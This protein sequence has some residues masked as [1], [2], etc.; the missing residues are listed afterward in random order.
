[1][2]S[3]CAMTW[4]VEKIINMVLMWDLWNISFFGRGDVSPTHSEL[5]RF[6]LGSKAKHQVSFPVVILL[7]INLSPSAI[8]IMSL[9]DVTRSSL[10]SG[11]KECGTN[12]AHNF[13][14]PKSC[15]S[16]WCDLKVIFTKSATAAMF[17]SVRLD[18]GHP[19]LSSSSTSSLPSQNWE[20][21]L[22]TLNRFRFS[23]PSAFCTNTSVCVADRQA[24]QQNFMATLFSFLPSMTY[25][26]NWLYMTS[27]NSY[28][29]EGKQTKLGV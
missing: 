4:R 19:P 11:V 18:F 20:Y 25:K 5:C 8:A 23:L 29:V 7:K 9:K 21:Q 1:M 24:L 22:K 26:D 15:F 12:R 16:V 17:T 6:V 14:F 3:L 13:I 2:N 10:C 28:T 27:D